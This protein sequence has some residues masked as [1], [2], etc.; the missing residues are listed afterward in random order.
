[1]ALRHVANARAALRGQ[2]GTVVAQDRRGAARRLQQ[3]ENHANSC[4]L[5]GAVA[6]DKGE[7]AAARHAEG[8]R[9]HGALVTEV[10]RKSTRLDD[11]IVR[12]GGGPFLGN[13]CE[14]HV[15]SPIGLDSRSVS[16]SS[17][18]RRISSA[19][20]SRNTASCTK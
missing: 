1:M 12:R 2:A 5:A 9:V 18:I 20:K 3:A 7:H 11:R 15:G 8:Y 14:V 4:G 17:T 19:E 16:F 13:V 10:S 6:A